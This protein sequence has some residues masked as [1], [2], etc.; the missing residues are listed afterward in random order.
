MKQK[1]ELNSPFNN[2]KGKRMGVLSKEQ[3]LGALDLKTERLFVPEWNGEV[4]IKS[5]TGSER[6][7]FE[8]KMLEL[9]ENK[10][11]VNLANAR[12]NL[13]ALSLIDENDQPLFTLKDV[14]AL[15][16]K[17]ASALDRIYTVAARLSGLSEKDVEDLAKN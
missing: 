4:I 7:Q 8:A 3:I 6:D 16:K 15:G 12:A 17:N 11:T 13:I 10:Y 9:K 14:Q 2:L 5:L 1:G